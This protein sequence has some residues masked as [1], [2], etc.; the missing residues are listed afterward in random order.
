MELQFLEYSFF[1]RSDLSF[2]LKFCA[3]EVWR[4]MW[5]F[6]AL[7]TVLKKY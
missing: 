5:T 7:K 3:S 6:S 4:D 2:L 1:S